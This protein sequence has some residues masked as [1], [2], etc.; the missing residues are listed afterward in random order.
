MPAP[1]TALLPEQI[2]TEESITAVPIRPGVSV[3][4]ILRHLNYKT[5]FALAEFVDNAVQSYLANKQRLEALHGPEFRLKVDIIIEPATPSRIVVRDNAAGIA[6]RDF[7][8]A[9]RP[10]AIP[11]DR[12]GLSEFGMGMKSAACWFAPRW[13]VRTKALGEF[14][15][16]M[17]RFDV[18]KIVRDQLEELEI[19]EAP[20]QPNTHFT[21]IVLDEPYHLPAGRTVGKIKD[22]LTDI[23]RVYMREGTL[24]LRFNTDLLEYSPPRILTAPYVRRPDDGAKEWKRE[25]DFD[26][27]DGLSAKGFAGLMDPMN[28]N[29]SGFALFRRKRLIEGSGDEGYRPPFIFGQPGNFR[30]RRLFGELHL[31]GFEVSHTKDG[32]RWDENEQ[33]FLELLREKLDKDELPMLRQADLYRVQASRN[34]LAEAAQK[35]IT[36][37]VDAMQA[38]LPNALPAVASEQPVE[39][40]ETPLEPEPATLAA[41]EMSISF[42]DQKW[43]LRIELT[44]DPAQGDWLVVSDQPA[45]NDGLQVLEIR[46]SLVHPFMVNFAQT[47][48]ESVEALLR[49][50]AGLALSERLARAVGVKMVGTIRRNLNE[51]LREALAKP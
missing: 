39:T 12:T 29:R 41:R 43:L 4:S 36:R 49:V 16:R 44:S 48:P 7:P 31:E 11:P 23:Y 42:R 17:V 50:A 3:L 18:A 45:Q 47:D 22:H 40:T 13:S 10:A 26:F 25:I 21:E 28:T 51:L 5:W 35:A 32:F 46:L 38:T 8:R 9:F 20:S 24:E 37:A 30:W 1:R 27:G 6:L 15:E 19:G 14:A 2:A 33:P 34:E